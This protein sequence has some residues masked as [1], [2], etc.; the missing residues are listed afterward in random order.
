MLYS[1]L[2]NKGSMWRLV[3]TAAVYISNMVGKLH[4]SFRGTAYMDTHIWT[5][6]TTNSLHT[7]RKDQQNG[8]TVV[9]LFFF[10]F[11]DFLWLTSL[12]FIHY[13]F[14]QSLYVIVSWILSIYIFSLQLQN[15]YL[16][17]TKVETPRNTLINQILIICQSFLPYSQLKTV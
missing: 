9:N 4:T 17:Q 1:R 10:S 15:K 13:S 6:I 7:T 16:I 3:H 2:G 12:L 14:K 5:T 11:L 8:C